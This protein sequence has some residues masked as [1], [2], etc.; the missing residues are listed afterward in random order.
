VFG[1]DADVFRPE[2]WLE[3]PEILGKREACF[4]TVRLAVENN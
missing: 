4:L 1:P 2:R 3:D